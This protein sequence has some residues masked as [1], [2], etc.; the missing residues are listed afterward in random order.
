MDQQGAI[1]SDPAKEGNNSTFFISTSLPHGEAV[2]HSEILELNSM[3]YTS[4]DDTT[5][6]F[7][8]L[9]EVFSS[10]AGNFSCRPV[11]CAI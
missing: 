7:S 6:G 9:R 4:K 3:R 2:Y 10:I 8:L 5:G 1:D 11:R